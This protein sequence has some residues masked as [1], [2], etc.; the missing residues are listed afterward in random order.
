[1]QGKDNFDKDMAIFIISFSDFPQNLIS[2]F[3][4]KNLTSMN[5]EQTSSGMFLINKYQLK[6]L[7]YPLVNHLKLN[8]FFNSESIKERL[9]YSGIL[10]DKEEG[11]K[12]FQKAL[13]KDLLDENK[14]YE[15]IL[16]YTGNILSSFLFNKNYEKIQAIFQRY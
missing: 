3:L 4:E 14:D 1:M 12:E 6:D 2:N 11:Y 16:K 13:E 9:T 5:E 15:S 8:L 7:Y 10:F